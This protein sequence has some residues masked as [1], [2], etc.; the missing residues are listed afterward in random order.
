MFNFDDNL[1]TLKFIAVLIMGTASSIVL[2]EK[3]KNPIKSIL[4][5]ETSNQT[6]F[7]SK[8]S[9]KSA[10][11]SSVVLDFSIA[12]GESWDEK[13]SSNNV[14]ANCVNGSSITGFEYEDV[15]LAT[16]S[17]SFFSEAVIYF[18]DSNNGDNG[19][20]LTTGAGDQTSGTKTFNS[21][22]ILD[23]TDNGLDDIVSLDDSA[24]FIQF[25]ENV[26]DAENAID[27][28]YTSGK[29][30]V[31]GIDLIPAND[32]PYL[33]STGNP[34]SELSVSYTTDQ[35]NNYG[36]NDN[37]EFSIVLNNSGP[38]MASNVTLD[39][40]LSDKLQFNQLSC[41]DGTTVNDRSAL[42]NM[43]VNDLASN[44]SLI[45]LI[46]ALIVAYG[47]IENSVIVAADNDVNSNNNT[48]SVTVSG[49]FRVI[50]I[51]NIY[52][53]FILFLAF[54][55]VARKRIVN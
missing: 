26:D 54:I 22:G 9:N 8:N 43:A 38:G 37:I 15:T 27:A 20:R 29:V 19:L 31:W 10:P 42:S 5:Q 1:K 16:E 41:N 44:S 4:S 52:A 21:N 48:A 7:H 45:C 35:K 13:D 55:F 47:P 51:N 39:N 6:S 32:C 24:F 23:L 28:R 46:D 18:S 11:N 30:T 34:A 17:G 2:A 25:Y 14:V 3:Q 12:N 53:L 50:P 33:M 36:L 49:A 40:I